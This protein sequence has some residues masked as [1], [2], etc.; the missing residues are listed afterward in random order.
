MHDEQTLVAVRGYLA[1]RQRA[2]AARA[3]S[4]EATTHLHALALELHHVEATL[5]KI[6]EDARVRPRFL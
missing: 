3:T 2:M 6:R 1:A 4:I 5:D